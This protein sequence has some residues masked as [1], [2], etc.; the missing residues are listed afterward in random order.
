MPPLLI[1]NIR[2]MAHTSATLAPNI[3]CIEMRQPAIGGEVVTSFPSL[4]A[5]AVIVAEEEW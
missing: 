2:T 1:Q 3:A 5:L 4:R